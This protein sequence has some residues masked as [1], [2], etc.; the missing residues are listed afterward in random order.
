M[1]NAIQTLLKL[2]KLKQKHF[3][4]GYKSICRNI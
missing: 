1:N 2:K 4:Y 3:D